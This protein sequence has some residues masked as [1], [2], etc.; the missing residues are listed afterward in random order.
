MYSSK[1]LAA[2]KKT[3]KWFNTQGLFTNVLFKLIAGAHVTTKHKINVSIVFKKSSRK[4]MK[5]TILL[6]NEEC[7]V[8][9]STNCKCSY[10]TYSELFM[11]PLCA[12]NN[13]KNEKKKHTH[14]TLK[15]IEIFYNTLLI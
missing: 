7:I 3:K 6:G 8:Q 4:S 14:P 1:S 15:D 5:N 10:T 9:D 2:L 13:S 11:R 12:D